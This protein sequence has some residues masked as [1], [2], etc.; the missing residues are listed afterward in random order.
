MRVVLPLGLRLPPLILRVTSG[1][2]LDERH[3]ERYQY[4][5][6]PGS[7]DQLVITIW[8]YLRNPMPGC[9]HPLTSQLSL[10]LV[11]RPEIATETAIILL[12]IS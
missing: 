12:K 2:R 9:A 11:Y 8:A 1:N 5:L 4:A 3:A 10:R 7:C 6:R